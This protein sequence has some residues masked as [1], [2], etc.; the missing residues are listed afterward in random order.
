MFSILF[1]LKKHILDTTHNKTVA[2]NNKKKKLVTSFEFNSTRTCTHTV[3]SVEE[4]INF[5]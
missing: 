3:Y 2:D 1:I 5:T 4:K